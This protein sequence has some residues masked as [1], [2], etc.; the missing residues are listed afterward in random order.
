MA[1]LS[2]RE[3]LWNA[4]SSNAQH[5]TY[6]DASLHSRVDVTQ[7]PD[8]SVGQMPSAP[9]V[10]AK[11]LYAADLA[12]QV[13]DAKQR[14]AVARAASRQEAAEST[15]LGVGGTDYDRQRMAR[16]Q[17]AAAQRGQAAAVS[18]TSAAP[19]HS[20]Q[21]VS[22]ELPGGGGLR[23]GSRSDYDRVRMRQRQAQSIAVQPTAPPQGQHHTAHKYNQRADS[24]ELPGGGGLQLS[25]HDRQRARQAALDAGRAAAA[26]AAHEALQGCADSP[27][28]G[29]IVQQHS[30]AA[31]EQRR[32]S[33]DQLQREEDQQAATEKA[34]AQAA[35]AA[36]LQQQIQQK[37]SQRPKQ[38]AHN[39]SP[40]I[41]HPSEQQFSH[42]GGQGQGQE[43]RARRQLPPPAAAAPR[44]AASPD[45]PGGGG[46]RIGSRSD[47]DRQRMQQRQQAAAMSSAS[48][49][50]LP[51]ARNRDRAPSPQQSSYHASDV[52]YSQDEY[53]PIVR[54]GEYFPH[55]PP[56]H[57]VPSPQAPPPQW[58]ALDSAP[59]QTPPYLQH[60][61]RPDPTRGPVE[62]HAAVS[63]RNMHNGTPDGRKL[64]AQLDAKQRYRLELEQQ[65][66]AVA[67]RKAAAK[68]ATAAEDEQLLLRIQQQRAGDAA[69]SGDR[70]KGQQPPHGEVPQ[71][72]QRG[73]LGRAGANL[74]QAQGAPAF[75]SAAVGGIG[76][77]VGQPRSTGV[78]GLQAGMTDEQ[79]EA[80]KR[81][82]IDQ[83]RAL[84]AQIE[85]KAAAKAAAAK[86]EA[87]LEL[88]EERRLQREQG[89][90]AE[91]HRA[92]V[93]AEERR[94]AA[95][96]E[97]EERAANAAMAK[98]KR[99]AQAAE[100]AR[101][102]AQEA[103]EDARVQRERKEMADKYERER[104]QV[105]PLD[106]DSGQGGH[107]GTPT[108]AGHMHRAPSQAH[109]AGADAHLQ[110]AHQATG[111]AARQH[112][113]GPADTERQLDHFA[114]SQGSRDT[115]GWRGGI[116]QPEH[117]FTAPHDE[118]RGFNTAAHNQHMQRPYETAA[119]QQWQAQSDWQ[120]PDQA[121][122][123]PQTVAYH[124]PH[125]W[126]AAP[127]TQQHFT[128]PAA[129]AVPSSG[130][131][132]ATALQTQGSGAMETSLLDGSSHFVDFS[133]ASSPNR[134]QA[135]K[136]IEY[137]KPA[138]WRLQEN[139]PSTVRAPTSPLLSPQR[140]LPSRP[141]SSQSLQHHN[142]SAD[143]SPRVSTAP[144]QAETQAKGLHGDALRLAE[145]DREMEAHVPVADIVGDLRR[146]LG[147]A[148][149][150]GQRSGA[151]KHTAASHH[152][153]LTAR[154]L[155][156]QSAWLAE[157]SM[158]DG[159]DASVS[160]AASV[161]DVDSTGSGG[162]GQAERSG[163]PQDQSEAAPTSSSRTTHP[164]ASVH[165]PPK[166][167]SRILHV[168][169]STRDSPASSA[170]APQSA[171]RS[172]ATSRASTTFST[173]KDDWLGVLAGEDTMH[174]RAS[175]DLRSHGRKYGGGDDDFS[176][177]MSVGNMSI[178]SLKSTTD[179]EG[180]AQRNAARLAYLRE[181]E[182]EYNT[183]VSSPERQA[184]NS[185]RSAALEQPGATAS[186]IDS[187]LQ[188][189]LSQAGL[190]ADAMDKSVSLPKLQLAK[191]TA[192]FPAIDTSQ[193]LGSSRQTANKQDA[194][195]TE[196]YD[197]ANGGLK[198]TPQ[199]QHPSA[200]FAARSSVLAVP[201]TVQEEASARSGAGKQRKGSKHK[202]HRSK[203]QY[204]RK[205]HSRSSSD[206][207][208]VSSSG[209]SSDSSRSDSSDDDAR[210]LSATERTARAQNTRSS[211]HLVPSQM[212]HSGQM[213]GVSAG[214]HSAPLSTHYQV[215][216]TVYVQSVPQPMPMYSSNQLGMPIGPMANYS[217]PMQFMPQG[218]MPVAQ[219]A[220]HHSA[221][222][223]PRRSKAHKTK[224]SSRSAKAKKAAKPQADKAGR[225]YTNGLEAPLSYDVARAGG[226][227]DTYRSLQGNSSWLQRD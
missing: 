176:D 162:G 15:G 21:Q 208:Y 29:S 89:E 138:V 67:A 68:A 30:L 62:H 59:R 51:S 84:Q 31:A 153:P 47:Y 193:P 74:M 185:A 137:S 207:S 24:P 81:A 96:K 128:P 45:L 63:F 70:H 53:M 105:R 180:M 66:A 97:E 55:G 170:G 196:Q 124:A 60:R 90:L 52:Q 187:V 103:A 69:S 32:R 33:M 116:A 113:F 167:K 18:L 58:P 171:V 150:A 38:R 158:Q 56:G 164:E 2:L 12:R 109:L 190:P 163:S 110:A 205:A 216:Q 25:S 165:T 226:A 48:H 46:L 157:G 73:V 136:P 148:S 22:D 181:L 19:Q 98:A 209:P 201:E 108:A 35:Y 88:Q 91:K 16:Q 37:G 145:D 118:H 43:E 102:A 9:L 166:Q 142:G 106:R 8:R 83:A 223:P 198:P 177:T 224:K 121:P 78:A 210:P 217:V 214:Y 227:P 82:G 49:Q 80:K 215:P 4:K 195:S 200:Q 202:S 222:A 146:Q 130:P 27:R 10:A 212:H 183:S 87:E 143:V 11:A 23:L 151:A 44:R 93:Q 133:A 50:V 72:A 13:Q 65:M 179:Y 114:P 221:P 14:E 218:G 95:A 186:M 26:A 194:P 204:R 17:Q 64:Q 99:Q 141:A 206:R 112:L 41:H 101:L 131:S 86:A 129:H 169:D 147:V 191:A 219:H 135:M 149:R 154:S 111:A 127:Q 211:M 175:H 178:M 1:D 144:S 71:D 123:A 139:K 3:Q 225:S 61:G 172:G 107:S 100:A 20:M 57:D 92:E 115:A 220:G 54:P 132:W 76:A 182:L 213:H 85:A 199:Q 94:A 168:A 77:A 5:H 184:G 6:D 122:P 42:H 159:Q 203:K 36:A 34:A 126:Q 39:L 28:H 197:F 189:Y 117:A 174:S 140:Q 161:S 134:S 79:L 152:L 188:Q 155:Q 160:T 104:N 156:G 75:S 173:S 125:D 119:P 40:E 192:A 7:P 120:R